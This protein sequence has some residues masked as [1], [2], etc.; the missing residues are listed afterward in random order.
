VTLFVLGEF[1]DSTL[2]C[3]ENLVGG[4]LIGWFL[5]FWAW[6]HVDSLRR[7]DTC[8]SFCAFEVNLGFN[9][10]PSPC[11]WG[12]LRGEVFTKTALGTSCLR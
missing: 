5:N 10:V 8:V 7:G 6:V 12:D 1:S 4:N 3:E 2:N 9:W 11:V